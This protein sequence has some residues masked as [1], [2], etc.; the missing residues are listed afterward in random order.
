MTSPEPILE[1]QLVAPQP[2]EAP[3]LGRRFTVGGVIAKTVTVWWK[4]VLAFTAMSIVVYAPLTAVLGAFLAA[5]TAG[6]APSQEG[7]PRLAVAGG[8]V[9]LL[10]LVLA[11]V[12]AGAVTYGTV[13]HLSGE[14]VAVA[15]MI[16][17]GLRRGLPVVAVG[18]LLWLGIVLGMVLLFVPGLMLLVA[19][20]VAIPAAV[21]ERPGTLGAIRRSFAL[22]RGYRWGLFAAGLAVTVIV[23]V[24]AAVVQV[25]ATVVSTL[26]L[27]QQQ[28]MVGTIVAS[29]LGNVFF[30]AL[31]LVGISVAYHELRVA[32]EG[33][34]TAA[35]AKVFE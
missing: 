4:H 3:P 1:T 12:Q 29:Q 33:I 35:L 31:P 9:W 22:T 27:P 32:K 2:V 19:S 28:A 5:A 18:L 24:L 20:C 15:E 30:S 6:N 14:R 7:L 25:G 11:V 23:W 13:R 21:V 34:D 16:R 17:V 26:L 8:A 10:T